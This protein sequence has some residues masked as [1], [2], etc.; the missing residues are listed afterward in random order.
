MTAVP[1]HLRLSV[2]NLPQT[3][4][5]AIYFILG[6][7]LGDA[8]NDLRILH[9]VRSRYLKAEYVVYADQRWR[10][11]Y[12]NV[13]DLCRCSLRLH[14]AAPSAGSIT[15]SKPYHEVYEAIMEEIGQAL[16]QAPG[17]LALGGFKCADQLPRRELSLAMKARA[18]DLPLPDSR[19]RPY[20]PI[21]ETILNQAQVFLAKHGLTPGEYCV[22]APHTFPDKMWNQHAW[23]LLITGLRQDTGLPVL[24]LG[25]P[26]Y[27]PIARHLVHEAL[28]LPLPVVAGLIALSRGFIG[29][30][31]GLSHVAACYDLP[32]VVLNPQGKFPPFLIEPHSP[33]RWIHLTPGIY[34]HQPIPP[35]SVLDLVVAALAQRMPDRC[36]LCGQIPFVLGAR[37]SRI[38]Y[39]CRCGLLFA[40]D[41]LQKSSVRSAPPDRALDRL[42][43]TIAGLVKYK[44]HLQHSNE[45]GGICS[46]LV[47]AFEHWDAQSLSPEKLL[48]DTQRELWW[49]WDA[50]YR[51]LSQNGW[52]IRETQRNEKAGRR[53]RGAMNL[54]LY[55]DRHASLKKDC[56]L[57]VPWKQKL[58]PVK[59]SVHDQWLSWSSFWKVEEIEGLGWQLLREGK[60]REGRE[61]LRLGVWL[62]P[63]WRTISRLI[64]AE[65]QGI[66]MRFCSTIR[67]SFHH[68]GTRGQQL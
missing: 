24:L 21:D 58:V 16:K 46:P 6:P 22:V 9:E 44:E 30:D 62:H 26:G 25:V 33:Y 35:Q 64:R 56:V 11:L 27:P 59:R 45:E 61:L 48:A 68:D 3:Y 1:S 65:C 14:E 10:A 28:G 60:E 12:E 2:S 41:A 57:N 13:P 23:E 47:I 63:R 31:S 66:M 17:Y 29:L 32:I 15:K 7:G 37:S 54:T 43:V 40:M 55:A 39:L 53:Q 34:G 38:L 4:E 49:S 51:L 52:M 8:V 19:C 50:V 42:P 20:L 67:F 36:P 18:I 5:G